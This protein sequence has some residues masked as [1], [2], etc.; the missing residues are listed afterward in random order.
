ML[1]IADGKLPN[2]FEII[3]Q[4]EVGWFMGM[5]K[6]VGIKEKEK[7]EEEKRRISKRKCQNSRK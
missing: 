1:Q 5:K 4:P 6:L 2:P 3:N 7:Q